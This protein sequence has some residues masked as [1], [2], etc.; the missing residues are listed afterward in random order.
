MNKPTQDPCEIC[1]DGGHTEWYCTNG[2]PTQ[3]PKKSFAQEAIGALLGTPIDSAPTQDPIN[4][5]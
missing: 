4:K 5:E 2:R 3:D 1:G